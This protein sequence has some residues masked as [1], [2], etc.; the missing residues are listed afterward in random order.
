MGGQYAL[1]RPCSPFL[2]IRDQ[3][4]LRVQAGLRIMALRSSALLRSAGTR[5]AMSTMALPTDLNLT[6]CG[7]QHAILTGHVVPAPHHEGCGTGRA[8]RRGL[9]PLHNILTY[10]DL[11]SRDP[12][13]T[14][15]GSPGF[16]FDTASWGAVMR[17][18]SPNRFRRFDELPKLS[19]ER[20][21][22]PAEQR[23]FSSLPCLRY[24]A[25][26]A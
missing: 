4:H 16:R 7:P 26:A 24:L 19:C 15:R 6:G 1:Q 13:A 17:W 10:N 23:D 12:V 21:A 8:R 18:R 20:Q 11:A 25:A 9:L 14:A 3:D 5:C 2:I 22:G